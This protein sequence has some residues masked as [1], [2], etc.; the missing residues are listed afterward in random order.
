MNQVTSAVTFPVTVPRAG[1]YR[2]GIF[3]GTNAAPGRHALFVDGVLNQVVQ[4]SATL[5]WT[6]RGRKDV[7][8]QLGAGTHQISVRTSADGVTLLPGS[9][10]T[11]DK[12]DLTQV[13]GVEK[14]SYTA[15][16]ARLAGDA[17]VARTAGTPAIVLGTGGQATYYVAAAQDGYQDLT[18]AY[19]AASGSR[20]GLSVDGRAV[21]GLRARP[22]ASQSRARVHL[23]AGITKVDVTG[24]GLRVLG[25]TVVRAAAADAQG[26]YAVEAENARLSGT[27]AVVTVPATSGS[28]A[29]GGAYVGSIGNGA[30]NTLTIARPA[31]FGPGEYDL[32]VSYAN[33][34]KNTG[35][36]YN[37]DAISRQLDITE[38]GGTTTTGVYRYNYAWDNFWS[39]VTPVKLTTTGGALVLGKA[40]DFGP[41]VDRV[42]L[43][44][45]VLEVENT[46]RPNG[47][48]IG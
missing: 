3:Y 8:L 21:D 19:D 45:F 27:A 23:A 7:A 43:A 29:S 48:P 14:S 47:G 36:A 16:D 38:V 1:T 10:V 40:S 9:D 4:Y 18:I 41:N 6:Y 44:K 42:E 39:Q 32:D 17:R 26:I 25:L 34:A 37:T 35:H 28:N 24:T 15:D 31:N 13:T 46:G 22:G 2:L 12:F 30:A 11:L 5:G 33:A 20:I